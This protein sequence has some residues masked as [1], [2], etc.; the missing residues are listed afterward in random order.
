VK[1]TGRIAILVVIASLVFGALTIGAAYAVAPQETSIAVQRPIEALAKVLGL[2]WGE[3]REQRQSGKS[4]TEIAK[5]KGVE[6]AKLI[7]TLVAARKARL[8]AAVKAGYVTK[9]RAAEILKLYEETVK[10]RVNNTGTCAPFG[11]N[12][13]GR[14]GR[15][16]GC[17]GPGGGLGVRGGGS[18]AGYQGNAL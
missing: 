9:E 8:D 7:E 4:L 1:T 17:G 6:E 5:S 15:G 11:P 14:Q 3:I 18:G 16:A 13:Q 12:G 10:A 2:S